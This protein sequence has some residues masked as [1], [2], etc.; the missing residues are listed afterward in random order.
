MPHL[1]RT[2]KVSCDSHFEDKLLDV[3]GLYL[4]PP[5]H[6]LVLRC[7]QVQNRVMH[8]TRCGL[9]DIRAFTPTEFAGLS[10]MSR[11]LDPLPGTRKGISAAIS[12]K[13][14]MP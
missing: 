5:E 2:F 8:C 3:V 1:S 7:D 4:N 6:P 13:G 11:W 10:L 12:R 9:I 14:G